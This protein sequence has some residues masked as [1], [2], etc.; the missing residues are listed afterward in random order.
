MF[1]SSRYLRRSRHLLHEFAN[2]LANKNF[3]GLIVRIEIFI[4]LQDLLS[5]T[6]VIIPTTLY[7]LIGSKTVN[8]LVRFPKHAMPGKQQN[9]ILH[10]AVVKVVVKSTS[11]ENFFLNPH[12]FLNPINSFLNFKSKYKSSGEHFYSRSIIE[13]SKNKK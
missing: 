4:Q 6:S 13:K 9:N 10:Y 5:F 3:A 12:T 8:E 1:D 11:V 2:Y 7:A